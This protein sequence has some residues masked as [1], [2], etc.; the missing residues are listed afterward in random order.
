MGADGVEQVAATDRPI[1]RSTD[2]PTDR[3][4]RDQSKFWRTWSIASLTVSAALPRTGE[5]HRA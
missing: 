2:R 4:R 1:D 3:R 5:H